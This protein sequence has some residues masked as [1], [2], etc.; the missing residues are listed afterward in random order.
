GRLHGVRPVRAGARLRAGARARLGTRRVRALHHDARPVATVRRS[1]D[2]GADLQA[3]GELYEERGQGDKARDYY[4]RF[5]D[6]WKN[7]DPER[8]PM[9]RDVKQRLVKLTAEGTR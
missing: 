8:Q 2:P 4:G 1:R 6:L 5:V 9:V 7:A 3:P